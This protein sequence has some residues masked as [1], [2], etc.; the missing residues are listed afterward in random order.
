MNFLTICN[1]YCGLHTCAQLHTAVWT[2]NPQNVPLPP[3]RP[4]VHREQTLHGKHVL[5]DF[6]KQCG[7]EYTPKT[8]ALVWGKE[9]SRKRE[10]WLQKWVVT[11]WLQERKGAAF[12]Y[13][14]WHL[15]KEERLC[16][17]CVGSPTTSLPGRLS[18]CH[19]AWVY[20]GNTR[21]SGLFCFTPFLPPQPCQAAWDFQWLFLSTGGW[22]AKS[23]QLLLSIQRCRLLLDRQITAKKKRVSSLFREG[24]IYSLILTFLP[25]VC[26]VELSHL[27]F[28]WIHLLPTFNS[29]KTQST[30]SIGG[31][32]L[33]HYHTGQ[34]MLFWLKRYW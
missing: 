32:Q 19:M 7:I 6:C 11:C 30:V 10:N 2:Q 25:A 34:S 13:D 12:I 17:K 5:G 18:L 22:L 20:C 27:C 4:Q 28:K 23:G 26:Q 1:E 16:K 15:G 8:N 31:F 14:E 3:L 33:I 24:C 9:S 29:P 21:I